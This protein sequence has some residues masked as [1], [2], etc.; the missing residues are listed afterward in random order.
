MAP[1]V[2]RSTAPRPKEPKIAAAPVS[3]ERLGAPTPKETKPAPA[4]KEQVAATPVARP[5]PKERK[6]VAPAPAAR[7]A[8]P[9]EDVAVA[10]PAEP[11]FLAFAITPW[12]EVRVDGKTIGVSP[13][14]Q[15]IKV[16]AGRHRVEVRNSTFTPLVQVVEV[17]P[18][19]R[20]RIRH[21]FR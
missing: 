14:L 17:K 18:G 3:K 7:T 20:I 15:E 12:G 9:E 21:R 11:G 8:E 16:G 13:P 2:T 1:V 6:S 19:E 5:K 4:P 10:A